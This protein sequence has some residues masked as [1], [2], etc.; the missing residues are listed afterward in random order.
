MTR[1]LTS[2]G[3][4]AAWEAGIGRRPLDRAIAILWAAGIPGDLAALPMAERDRSLLHVRAATFGLTL[5]ARADCPACGEE[6]EMM[7]D[8]Q[9]LVSALVVPEPEVLRI[10]GEEFCIRSLT[11]HD[12]AAA[13]SASEG[14]VRDLLCRRLTG[15]DTLPDTMLPDLYDAISCREAEGELT[16]HF[17][18]S[19]CQ[20][21]W[22]EVL[23]IADFLW[24]EVDAGARRLLGEIAEIASAFGWSEREILGLSE[25]R[26]MVYLDL[27]RRA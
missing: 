19:I 13:A 21:E 11:S 20:M 23:D 24:A 4:L 9:A 14:E 12:V 6:L 15:R 1:S 17:T 2:S 8:A 3:I 5:E 10:R 7:F 22:Q 16:A 26:R 25:G 27:A 18:C